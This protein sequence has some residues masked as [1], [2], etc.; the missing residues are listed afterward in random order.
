MANEKN[1]LF[2]NISDICGTP[3]RFAHTIYLRVVLMCYYHASS[4]QT[5]QPCDRVG[6]GAHGKR[7]FC[8]NNQTLTGRSSLGSGTLIKQRR[9]HRRLDF[10]PRRRKRRSTRTRQSQDDNGGGGGGSR[11]IVPAGRTRRL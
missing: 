10:D 6:R 1:R 4:G 2:F 11:D 5:S 3:C 7:V 8:N 9:R